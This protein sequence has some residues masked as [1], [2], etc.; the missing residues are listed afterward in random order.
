ME[1]RFQIFTVLIASINRSIKKIKT[2]EM[3]EFNLKSPHVSCLYYLHK[4]DGLT[5]KELCDICEEDKANVSRSVDFLEDN[6]YIASSSQTVKKYR[7]PLRLT[8]KGQEVGRLIAEKVDRVLDLAG[9][10]LSD[11]HRAVMYQSLALVNTNLQK[12]CLKYDNK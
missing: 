8:E 5:A 1:E 7:S 10:G 12:I 3:A 6:G 2:E 11:E 9:E 4:N